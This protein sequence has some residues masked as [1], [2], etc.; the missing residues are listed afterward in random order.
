[1]NVATY[2]S[3]VPK[4]VWLSCHL[5]ALY[6]RFFIKFHLWLFPISSCKA[7]DFRMLFCIFIIVKV[8]WN[9]TFLSLVLL[10]SS[11]LQ[12]ETGNL[13]FPIT[14]Y[15]CSQ[16]QPER[17]LS[18]VHIWRRQYYQ[19]RKQLCCNK[20]SRCTKSNSSW[21]IIIPLCLLL[22]SNLNPHKTQY[23]NNVR[24]FIFYPKTC[25]LLFHSTTIW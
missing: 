4:A 8:Y 24:S 7:V 13:L 10:P 15:S 25:C 11:G 2:L 21:D 22:S 20:L 9:S 16:L 5:T 14:Q 6:C 3:P 17:C 19:F 18:H 12:T 23:L 1:M